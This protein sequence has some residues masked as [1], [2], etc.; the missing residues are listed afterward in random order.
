MDKKNELVKNT[1]ILSVGRIASQFISFL[2]L[3]LYTYFL[4]PE[5][6][7]LIDLILTY[8]V[9]LSPLLIIQLDRAVFR[10]LI[11][12]RGDKEKITQVISSALA[13]I[14]PLVVLAGIIFI[15]ISHLLS[16]PYANL[17]AIS[18]LATILSMLA[19]QFARG[20]GQ[21]KLYAIANIMAAGVTLILTLVLVVVLKMGAAGVL[22]SL[23]FSNA[24]TFIFLFWKLNLLDYLSVSGVKRKVQGQLLSFSWPLVPS[25]ISWWFIR[26]SDRTIIVL[27]LGAAANGI[28]AAASK[29]SLIF[30]AIY[31]IFDLAWTE[32]ASTHINSKDRDKYFSEVHNASF[33]VFGVIGLCLIAVT[34]VLF[35]VIIGQQY[36]EAY[37]YIPI[38]VISVLFQIYVAMYSVIYLAKRMTRE[39]LVTSICAAAISLCL[40]LIFIQT[41][42]LY[43]AA[44]SSA[45]AFFAMAIWRH[46]DVKKYVTIDYTG[47]IFLKLA[48][49]YLLIGSLFYINDPILNI[50]SIMLALVIAV[51]LTHRVILPLASRAK[52]RTRALFLS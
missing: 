46:Y 35:K 7:G 28:Y 3:P 48:G 12:A 15:A 9:L 21:N 10:D 5:V 32:S 37:Q 50:L 6:Y 4:E 31:S 51:L 23:I 1:I 33:R 25:A 47:H 42:G 27:V 45:I 18:V 52:A 17:I 16:I 44:A 20:F 36:Q 29:Y 19:S 43:A 49:A 11:D 26:A 38:V 22:W 39:I 8:I 14:A 13:I 34:P 40:N 24:T 2:L 30:L 41:F